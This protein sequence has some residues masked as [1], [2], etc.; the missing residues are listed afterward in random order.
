MQMNA[1]CLGVKVQKPPFPTLR[2]GVGGNDSSAWASRMKQVLLEVDL[3][4]GRP[5]PSLSVLVP[6]GGFRV[7]S[8][9]PRSRWLWFC[10]CSSHPRP[11]SRPAPGQGPSS[12]PRRQRCRGDPVQVMHLRSDLERSPLPPAEL[13]HHLPPVRHTLGSGVSPFLGIA[14]GSNVLGE[15]IPSLQILVF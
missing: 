8:Q 9:N 13:N 12:S 7:D 5:W 11:L 3:A 1:A 15:P 6:A 10:P 4:Q 2:S 14:A